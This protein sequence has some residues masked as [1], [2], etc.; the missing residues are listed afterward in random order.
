MKK[1]VVKTWEEFKQS[2]KEPEKWELPVLSPND[3]LEAITQLIEENAEMVT[4]I[5][6]L[7]KIREKKKYSDFWMGVALAR[8]EPIFKELSKKMFG[9]PIKLKRAEDVKE[10]M[11]EVDSDE[12]KIAM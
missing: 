5:E 11:K 10:L 6:V 8:T 7:D 3:I 4:T 2:F 9:K 12:N 1:K